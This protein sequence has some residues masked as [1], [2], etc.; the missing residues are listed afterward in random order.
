MRRR[1]DRDPDLSDGALVKRTI[2]V[3]LKG[4]PVG[5]QPISPASSPKT[6]TG[7][8][9][10]VP[11]RKGPPAIYEVLRDPQRKFAGFEPRY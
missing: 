8:P 2:G 5:G 11:P 4:V 1:H 9:V 10:I 3:S 7:S 6:V